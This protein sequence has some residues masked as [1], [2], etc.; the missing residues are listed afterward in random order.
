MEEF[1][2][3]ISEYL[4]VFSPL[5]FL[6]KINIEKRLE[7]LGEKLKQTSRSE[8]VSINEQVL[9]YVNKILSEINLI[10]GEQKVTLFEFKNLLISGLTAVKLSIIPQY[11]DAV[12]VGGFKEV[13]L[14]QTDY[15]FL[16]LLTSAVPTF[17]EDVAILSDNDLSLLSGFNVI[18]EPKIKVANHRL[19]EETAMGL[20]CFK[21]GLFLSYSISSE[22]GAQN[23]RSQLFSVL[24]RSFTIKPFMETERY[25]TRAQGLRNYSKEISGFVHEG[26]TDIEEAT[27]WRQ[28]LN[29]KITDDIANASKKQ[30]KVRLENGNTQI[31]S[32]APTTLES[33]YSCPYRT[34]VEKTLRVK[35]RKEGKLDAPAF[36]TIVHEI[37]FEFLRVIDE[38]TDDNFNLIFNKIAQSVS[39][40]KIY[41][42]LQGEGEKEVLFNSLIKETE[43][44][45]KKNYEWAKNGKFKTQKEHLE[46][47]FGVDNPP[48]DFKNII[49]ND[50]VRLKGVIDRVDV[51]G[52]YARVI[53]YKT[54][55]TNGSAKALFS[56]EKLQL[57]LYALAL[58]DKK[59][60]GA[61]YM[62]ISD[63]YCSIDDKEQSLVIGNTLED[64]EILSAS[65]KNFA[66]NNKSEYLPV[67]LSKQKLTNTLSPEQMN[68]L[69]EYA[70]QMGERAISQMEDGVIAPSPIKDFCNN[71]KFSAVCGVEE[72]RIRQIKKVTEETVSKAIL[73][74]NDG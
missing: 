61:Y 55:K 30:L 18:V 23:R 13:G 68:A 34:F 24:E 33:Y 66:E 8:E 45:C 63:E 70:K 19:R 35:E 39:Q 26:L 7:A 14:Y 29:D 52:D 38:V 48:K 5:A 40:K 12:F 44:F 36:G 2:K 67:H 1:R 46:V 69:V 62:P 31:D 27:A 64:Q 22:S 74:E 60:S 54:G 43:K 73:G 49:L 50:R 21:K 6:D 37:F 16:P 51:F 3:K 9:G 15:V 57:Y 58:K 42:C 59:L 53:D 11:N 72:G 25:L 4:K 71:C 10:L 47:N 56:G 65:D 41:A 17:K 32:V 20:S 28:A